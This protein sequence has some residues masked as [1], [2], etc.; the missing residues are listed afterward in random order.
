MTADEVHALLA[1]LA[2]K[3]PIF[4]SEADFQ[5]AFAWQIHTDHPTAGVRL[6]CVLMTGRAL[7][8]LIRLEDKRVGI[9]LKYLARRFSADHDGEPFALRNQAA[10]DIRR[11]DVIKDIVRIEDLIAEGLVATGYVVVLTNDP[12]YWTPPRTTTTCD[13]AFRLNDGRV[14]TGEL[15]WGPTTGAGTMRGREAAFPLRGKYPL[16]WREYA[17]VNDSPGGRFRYLLVAV[18]EPSRRLGRARQ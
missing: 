6:E 14:L 9:E 5:H 2:E 13:A 8:V 1:Q 11:Y 18:P 3:R 17:H 15:R 10:Q 16:A 12:S 7:D 4:H